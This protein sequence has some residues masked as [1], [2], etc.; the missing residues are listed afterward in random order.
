MENLTAEEKQLKALIEDMGVGARI[1]AY[2]ADMN[3]RL[4]EPHF[5]GIT[6]DQAIQLIKEGNEQLSYMNAFDPAYLYLI[7]QR[8]A[9]LKWATLL[10]DEETMGRHD[11]ELPVHALVSVDGVTVECQFHIPQLYYVAHERAKLIKQVI[12]EKI[13]RSSQFGA[14]LRVPSKVDFVEL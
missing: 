1:K 12:R 8:N 11:H 3:R 7:E 9:M 14:S 6:Y 4:L 10:N 5:K 13:M 2:R